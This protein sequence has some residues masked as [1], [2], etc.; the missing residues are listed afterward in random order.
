MQ[1][2]RLFIAI[3]LPESIKNRLL[4]VQKQI[5]ELFIGSLDELPRQE[6]IRWTKKDNLHITLEFVGYTDNDGVLEFSRAIE[7]IAKKNNPFLVRLNKICYAPPGKKEP[8]MVWT[9]GEKSREFA[10]LRQ[11]IE[12]YFSLIPDKNSNNKK[13]ERKFSPHVTLGRIRQWQWKKIEPEERPNIEEE[14]NLKFE[15]KS[16]ELMESKLKRGGPEYTILKTQNL[17]SES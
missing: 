4:K 12:D 17:K 6:V 3:N 7:E 11:T 16:I 15:V 9:I 14:I 2:H 5:G 10:K 13:E 1:Q 8:R